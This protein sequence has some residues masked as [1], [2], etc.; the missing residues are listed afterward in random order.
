MG[1]ACGRERVSAGG[2]DGGSA[3]GQRIDIGVKTR[4]VFTSAKKKKKIQTN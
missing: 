3:G 2:R 4:R 1:S